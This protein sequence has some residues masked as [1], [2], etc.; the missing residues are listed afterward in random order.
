MVYHWL[1]VCILCVTVRVPYWPWWKVRKFWSLCKLVI[2]ASEYICDDYAHPLKLKMRM[3]AG[4]VLAYIPDLS[5]KPRHPFEM[6]QVVLW[7]DHTSMPPQRGFHPV[8]GCPPSPPPPRKKEKEKRR[9][10][11]EERGS[12]YFGGGGGGMLTCD[13][14]GHRRCY[15][16]WGHNTVF[17]TTPTL[18]PNHTHFCTITPVVWA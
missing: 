15:R 4:L 17:S 1:I 16:L 6:L 3:Q 7:Y 13:Q 18:L 8:G 11:K 5:K 2:K 12:M 14:Q 9:K 10:G